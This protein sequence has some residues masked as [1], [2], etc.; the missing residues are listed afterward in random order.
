M[1]RQR[2]FDVLAWTI[3][4]AVFL[5]LSFLLGFILYKAFTFVGPGFLAIPLSGAI[6]GWALFH[7]VMMGERNWEEAAEIRQA[8][9]EDILN[10]QRESNDLIRKME[11]LDND[12]RRKI[13]E[14]KG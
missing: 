14:N 13:E 11:T 3:L 2:F 9:S 1:T 7:L 12:L 6:F 10:F 5:G 8:I 4:G